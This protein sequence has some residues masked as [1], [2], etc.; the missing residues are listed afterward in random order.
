[1]RDEG[2]FDFGGPDAVAGD[3]EHVVDAADDPE[4]AVFVATST[5]A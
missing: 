2:A 5:V 4:I 3:V 1:M